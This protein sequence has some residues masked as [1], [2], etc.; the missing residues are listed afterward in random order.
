M[1]PSSRAADQAV[2]L[3]GSTGAETYLDVAKILDAAA[4]SGADAV[5]PGYG[6]LAEN[7][8]FARAV[9]DAGLVWI[10]PPAEVISALGDKVRARAIA[11]EAGAPLAAGHEGAGGRR[12]RGGR[13]RAGAR[14]AAGDQGRPRGRR[15]GPAGGPQ[16]GRGGR[17]VRGGRARG[18]RG[19]RTW[20]VLPRELH[21][22]GLGTSR[23]RCWP[24]PTARSRSSA[25][26]TAASSGATRRWSRRPRP[27]SSPTSSAPRSRTRPRRSAARPGYVNAGT[28]EFL[29]VAGRGSSRSSR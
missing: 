20:R 25:P 10:G 18:H 7:A 15:A 6:F 11:E 16:P 17:P 24:T 4:Q 26:A 29:L 3:G 1:R 19:L 21:R 23:S 12:R 13:L 5:H 22:E 2:A 27:R 28:V 14:A 9:V 8:D